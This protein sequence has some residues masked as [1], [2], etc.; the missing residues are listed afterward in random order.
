MIFLSFFHAFF[1]PPDRRFPPAF[2]FITFF[3]F[4]FNYFFFFWVFSSEISRGG[5]RGDSFRPHFGLGPNKAGGGA[6]P[7]VQAPK[8]YKFLYFL[9]KSVDVDAAA[10]QEQCE[11]P[12]GAGVGGVWSPL[13]QGW[14]S[15]WFGGPCSALSF[16]SWNV[17]LSYSFL[18]SKNSCF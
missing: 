3:S 7:P 13:R 9:Y 17:Y 12:G 6:A 2:G 11:G 14:W 16:R 4:S 15:G 1:F 18:F 8:S 10:V 5:R